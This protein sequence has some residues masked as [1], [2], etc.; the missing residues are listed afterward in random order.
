MAENA[1]AVTNETFE[2]EVLKADI[3]VMVDFWAEWC[4]PCKMLAPVVEELAQDFAGRVKVVKLDTENSPETAAQFGIRGIPT[5]LFFRDGEVVDRL[6]GMALKSKIEDRLNRLLP[7]T[8][9]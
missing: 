4:A 1:T 3:P 8:F 9:S 2:E 5:L 7:L 6:V